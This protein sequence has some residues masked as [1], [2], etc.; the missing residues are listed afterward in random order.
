MLAVQRKK[1][2][3]PVS[4]TPAAPQPAPALGGNPVPSQGAASCACGGTCP[5]CQSAAAPS[6]L[7]ITQTAGPVIARQP[8]PGAPTEKDPRDTVKAAIATFTSEASTIGGAQGKVDAASFETSINNWYAKVT[9]TQRLIKDQ[10]SGDVL[11]DRDLQAAYIS[12][13]R[14][15]MPKAATALGTTEDALYGTNSARIP[16][17]AWQSAHR[18]ET[19]ISTPLDQGQAVDP[20]SGDASFSAGNGIS[21]TI[22]TDTVDPAIAT[23]VTRL[24]IPVDIPFTTLIAANKT[25]TIDTF[26]PPSSSATIQTAYPPGMPGSGASGYG[27]GTTAEDIAGGKVN[28]QSTTLR[29]HEGNHGLDFVTYLKANPLP[30]FKGTSGMTKT[31]FNNEITA[32]KSAIKAYTASAEKASSKL[33]HCVGT[34]I[35]TYNQANAKPGAKVKLECTP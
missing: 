2:A 9:D 29:W 26:T 22:L 25:E 8:K 31:K 3:A 7:P 33:T 32:Y 6:T 35:D 5:R 27:R 24:V 17:W 1:P 18:R 23:P 10:L 12:A 19:N 11:L 34:T 28:P 14:A 13:I 4:P 21:V 30:A 16:L 15:L 20:L